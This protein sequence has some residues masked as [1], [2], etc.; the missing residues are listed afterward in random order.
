MAWAKLESKTL[1]GTAA[2][3]DTD[4][5]TATKFMQQMCHLFATGGNI[6]SA[7]MLNSDV[8]SN[9]AFRWSINGGGDG[10][11]TT[12]DPIDI[13]VFNDGN[14]FF[15]ETVIIN[16]SAE[17][18]LTITHS[19][20]RSSAGAGSVPGRREISGKWVN[21]SVQATTLGNHNN[22]SGSFAIDSNTTAL[23]T[24]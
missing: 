23:G 20:A 22:E 10:T 11:A 16:I 8:G 13:D 4:S 3:V 5:F 6:F 9:Y 2:T 19:V 18:K 15:G 14:D 12:Q 21:T 7:L 17:E 1:T 24:D